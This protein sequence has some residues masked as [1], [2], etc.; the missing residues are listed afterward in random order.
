MALIIIL[1]NV[2]NLAPVSDYNVRV[3]VGDGTVERSTVL[4]AGE[5]KG[6]A[7]DDGWKALVRAFMDSIGG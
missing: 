2:S 7:R 5:V 3:L 4:Y 6:H 1:Q